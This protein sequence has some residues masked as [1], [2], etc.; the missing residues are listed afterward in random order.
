VLIYIYFS[1]KTLADNFPTAKKCRLL[2]KHLHQKMPKAG[3]K[4]FWG[5]L[6]NN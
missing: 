4:R 1:T 2:S 3:L 6:R 5:K